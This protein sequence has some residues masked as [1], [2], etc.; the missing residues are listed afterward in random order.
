MLGEALIVEAFKILGQIDF[1]DSEERKALLHF[2]D[3]SIK[4]TD[5]QVMH[6]LVLLLDLREGLFNF[7]ESLLLIINGSLQM[8]LEVSLDVSFD[9]LQGLDNI[10]DWLFEIMRV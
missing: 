6:N 4:L 1:F 2:V 7:K 10:I 8:W 3:F 5:A 9:L